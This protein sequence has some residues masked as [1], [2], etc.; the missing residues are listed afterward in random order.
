MAQLVLSEGAASRPRLFRAMVHRANLIF[1]TAMNWPRILSTSAAAAL[2][3]AILGI[4]SLPPRSEHRVPHQR[5][6]L[7]KITASVAQVTIEMEKPDLARIEREVKAGILRSSEPDLNTYVAILRSLS[8]KQRVIAG[9]R[10]DELSSVLGAR[11]LESGRTRFGGIRITA[12]RES[13]PRIVIAASHLDAAAARFLVERF[14]VEFANHHRENTAGADEFGVQ[15]L[16]EKRT[17]LE[18]RVSQSEADLAAAQASN[19]EA[20]IR[21]TERAARWSREHI[22]RIEARI[23]DIATRGRNTQPLPFRVVDARIVS[24]RLWNRATIDFTAE[25]ANLAEGKKTD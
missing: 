3:I 16:K 24:G 14:V 5:Y 18:M 11:F 13:G 9:L 2:L 1:Q 20:A 15:F 19:N 17:E 12:D 23:A 7:N 4:V 22:S 8:F 21:E 25:L 10:P 6:G